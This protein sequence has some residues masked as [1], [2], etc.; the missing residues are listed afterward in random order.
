[1]LMQNRSYAINKVMIN[2]LFDDNSRKKFEVG[3]NDIIS[4]AYNDKGLR[5]EITGKVTTV[6]F[7]NITPNQLYMTIDGSGV[8]EGDTRAIYV[9]HILDCT[10]INKFDETTL[11]T[12]EAGDNKVTNLRVVDGEIEYSQNDTVSWTTTKKDVSLNVEDNKIKLSIGKDN[13]EATFPVQFRVVDGTLQF[14]K[15]G[16]TWTTLQSEVEVG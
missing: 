12:S 14:S 3:V 5:R 13:L 16:T 1:M 11:I 10:M 2:L 15:D 6:N 7:S 9:D 4:V 8:Y